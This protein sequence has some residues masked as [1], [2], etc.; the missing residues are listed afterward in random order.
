ML[1]QSSG[2]SASTLTAD[3]VAGPARLSFSAGRMRED[4]TVLGG[5]FDVSLGAPGATSWFVD[6]AAAVTLGQG[7]QGTARYRRGW[8][9]FGSDKVGQLST[10]A[11]AF[12]LS[13]AGLF[14]IGDR[15]GFRVSQPLRVRSG[16]LGVMLPVAYDYATLG[17]EYALTEINLAPEGQE[18]DLETFYSQLRADGWGANAF[19]RRQP[20][21]IRAADDDIGV[22]IQFAL[23]ILGCGESACRAC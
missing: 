5:R 13:K 19:L 7:W 15:L 3:T 20:G 21:H 9:G 1:P 17:T 12:D 18:V 2:F 22:A 8:T 16:G 6:G 23:E 11:F 14:R 4:S 10:D